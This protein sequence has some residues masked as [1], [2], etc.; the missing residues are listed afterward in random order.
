MLNNKISILLGG[1]IRPLTFNQY[2][3]R[4][5][6][7]QIEKAQLNSLQIYA[8][9]ALVWAGLNGAA[10]AKQL[11]FNI[12]FEQVCDW[13]D[14]LSLSDEGQ[15]ALYSVD[16]LFSENDLYKKQLGNIKDAIRLL[17]QAPDEDD[18]KKV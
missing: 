8:M 11:E 2:A 14:E 13:V 10:F 17:S 6:W 16:L 4:L 5:Y 3:L 12:S 1:E 9:Y 15:Q 18:K 7:Q